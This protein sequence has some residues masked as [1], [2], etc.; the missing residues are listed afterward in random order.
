[1]VSLV[2][3]TALFGESICHLISTHA[4]MGGYPLQDQGCS[5]T[6]Q[7]QFSDV[8]LNCIVLWTNGDEGRESCVKVSDCERVEV[9]MSVCVC[10]WISGVHQGR[11]RG[12]KGG[13]GVV[14]NGMFQSLLKFVFQTLTPSQRSSWEIFKSVYHFVLYYYWPVRRFV[15]D[16]LCHKCAHCFV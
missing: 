15:E 4:T 11:E 14:G 12:W 8:K 10:V 16:K 9:R 2:K 5:G 13:G 1:M 3:P 7:L 6:Q